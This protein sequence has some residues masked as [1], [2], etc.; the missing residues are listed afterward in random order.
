MTSKRVRYSAFRS[1]ERLITLV[2]LL[3]LFLSGAWA[4][5]FTVLR[6]FHNNADAR[7]PY[8]ALLLESNGNLY[9]ATGGGGAFD[10]GT[11]FKINAHRKETILHSFWGGDGLQPWTNLIRDP[12][13][14]F[15]GTTYDGGALEKG[16]CRHGCG[17]VFK[18]DAKGKVTVLHAFSGGSGGTQPQDGLVRDKSGNLYGT[19][20]AGGETSCDYG[21]GCGMVFRIGRNGKF[22][23]LHAFSGS[24]DGAR[25]WTELIQDT[26]GSFYGVTEGGGSSGYGTVFKI[27]SAGHETVLYS[28]TGAASGEYPVGQLARD[29]AGNLYGATNGGGDSSCY[30]CGVVFELDTAGSETVLHTFTGNPDGAFP[31]S[32]VIRDSEGNLYGTTYAGGGSSGCYGLGCGSVFKADANGHETV[33]HGFTGGSDGDISFAPLIL[34]KAGNLYGV[35]AG[36]GDQTCPGGC[37]VVF[38]IKP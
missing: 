34:D 1:F 33:L 6:D 13:G 15:Y 8:G 26:S 27:D 31:Y 9:G 28:F 4:Q 14:N 29:A 21:N 24:Q 18:L 32:G 3:C 20:T 16:Q 37:G 19:T 30:F 38:K 7:Y 2:A 23:V 35:A 5:N 36:G 11:V 17:T 25:P 10:Y 12:S 22:T